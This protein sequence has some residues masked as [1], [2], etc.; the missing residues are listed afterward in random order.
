MRPKR[1]GKLRVL[2]E[3][4][5]AAAHGAGIPVCVCGDLAGEETGAALLRKLGVDEL[6]VPSGRVSALRKSLTK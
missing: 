3:M 2:V 1:L 6:S 4:T 5:V